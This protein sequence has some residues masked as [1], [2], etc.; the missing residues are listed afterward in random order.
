M[1]SPEQ[2]KAAT[3]GGGYRLVALHRA[4]EEVPLRLSLVVQD[5]AEPVGGQ[6][7]LLRDFADASVYLGCAADA[8]GSVREWL[9][10]WVQIPELRYELSFAHRIRVESIARRDVGPPGDGIP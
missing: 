8:A 9:E 2:N 7:V 5:S 3:L 6:F 10:I 4:D 1:L